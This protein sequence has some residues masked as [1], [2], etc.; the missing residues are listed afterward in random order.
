VLPSRCVRCGA[1]S[2]DFLCGACTDYLVAYRPFWLNPAIL[3]GPSLIDLVDPREVALVAADLSQV[4]WHS[5]RTKTASADAVLLVQ[6]LRLDANAHPVFSVGDAEVLH[7]FL[8]DGRRA[9]PTSSEER[10]ALAAVCRYLSSCGWMPAHLASEYRLRAEVLEHAEALYDALGEPPSSTETSTR[11][12]ETE[13]VEAALEPSPPPPL[14]PVEEEEFAPLEPEPGAATPEIEPERPREAELPT[15]QPPPPEP[16][17][18]PEPPL[19]LPEPP[20]PGPEPEPEPEPEESAADRAARAEIEAMKG[21][22][23]KERT[24][25]ETWVRSRSEELR[26][27]EEFLVGREKEVASKEQRVEAEARAATER[28]VALEKDVA[29]REVL[30]FLGTVP[31]MSEPA[32]DVIAAA[33]PDMDALRGADGMALTQCKGVSAGLA[34]AIRYELAPGE[35]EDEQRASRLREEAH[36]FQAEG[37]YAAAL[38]CYDRLSR[39]HPEDISVWFDRAQLLVLLN[40]PAEAL[41]CYAR[42][43]N[44]DRRNRQAWFERANLLFGSGRLVDAVDALR[45]VLKIDPSKGG[46][47]ALRAEQLRRDGHPNEAILLFQAVLD[48]DPAEARSALGLGDSLLDL[49]DPEAAEALFTRALGKDPQN[50]PIVFRKGELLERK[51][52]W[53]A[54]IQYYNRAIALRWNLAGP[55]FAKGRILLDH[56]RAKEALEC[57]DKTVSFEPDHVGAWAGKAR[58]LAALGDRGAAIA[59]LER[60]SAIGP[61]EPAV[62]A[63][64]EAIG[65]SAPPEAKPSAA[66]TDLHSLAKAFEEIEDEPEPELPATPVP[67]DFG[68]FVESIEPEKEE[69]QVLVQLAELALEGG[70]PEMALL[71]YEQAI[72]REARSPDAWTGKGIALQQLERYREALEAYDRALAL[73]PDHALALKWR[74]TCVRHVEREADG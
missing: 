45:E 38:A 12:M 35:V 11:P 9:Q 52:R 24:D 20:G 19:P 68:A 32:A 13:V 21:V 70:D 23:E 27:K 63:A 7:A 66:P 61:N 73:K 14:P 55:W 6:L 2:R 33:F 60:A 28:L 43:I 72:G 4:E 39:A 57:F 31:G 62:R 22:V 15:P 30:R 37:D 25:V 29:R 67:S 47:I 42:V 74:T 65:A 46:D 18:R 59:A 50:A 26:A 40:R 3:P 44:L 17:P 64:R 1:S 34:R 51:G 10:A 53:G 48:A 36:A 56:D 71:R 5:P 54:A 49:G 16:V 8:Q 69:T 58:A 41:Q